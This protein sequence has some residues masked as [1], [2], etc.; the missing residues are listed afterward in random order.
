M[1][2][3]KVIFLDIDGCIIKH[4]GRG[5]CIQWQLATTLLRGVHDAFDAWEKAGHYIVLTTSRKECC[6]KDLETLLRKYGLFWDQ[7]VMGLPHGERILINDKKENAE[8]ACRAIE[9][10]RNEGLTSI[11][12]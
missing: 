1:T 8:P 7:L 3:N 10:V 5:A 6:R 9:L 4:D 11:N 12:L 2:S